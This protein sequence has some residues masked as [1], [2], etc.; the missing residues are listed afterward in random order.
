MAEIDNKNRSS[1]HF[2]SEFRAELKESTGD[3]K[4][5]EKRFLTKFRTDK[6]LS[7]LSLLK[8]PVGR[9]ALNSADTGTEQNIRSR[10]EKQLQRKN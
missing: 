4:K 9:R 5:I 2:G 8:Y 3:R 1:H 6:W 7:E 10:C